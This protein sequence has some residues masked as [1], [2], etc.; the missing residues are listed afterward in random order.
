MESGIARS[1][2]IENLNGA[3]RSFEDVR[4]LLKDQMHVPGMGHVYGH[5]CDGNELKLS[6]L[7]ELYYEK[8]FENRWNGVMPSFMRRGRTSVATPEG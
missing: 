1:V 3:V 4:E 5:D 2:C 7:D 6:P 8:A